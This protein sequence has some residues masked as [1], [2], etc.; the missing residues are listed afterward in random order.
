[1]H[2]DRVEWTTMP[3]PSTGAASVEKGEQDWQENAPH[4]L[5]PVLTKNKGLTIDVLDPMGY[6]CSLRINHLHPPFDNPAI[7]RALWGAVDQS[8]FMVAVTGGDPA[9]QRTPIGF[10]CPD[11]PMASTVGLDVLTGP[12]DYD[13]VKRDLKAAG[14]NGEKVTLLVPMDSQVL[15]PLGNVAADMLRRC[16]MNVDFAGQSF[17]TVVARRAKKDPPEKGGWNASAS[18]GQGMDW[19]EPGNS[20]ALRGDGTYL[21][22]YKSDRME[23]L[24]DRWLATG[25]LAE[26]K[27]ICVEIQKLAFEEVPFY[28]IGQYRQATAYRK[29]I[30]G[31]AGSTATFWN[32]RPA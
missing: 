20:L 27:R 11:T 31:V 18:N 23:A 14:Y 28:P 13:K 25:D 8:D 5:L 19:L 10:F 4:D 16:G 29:T 3:D 1:V 24:R 26:Q 7:R 9:Y 15:R 21:G 32:V 12:R 22:W 30:T 6:T 17:G 2:Y